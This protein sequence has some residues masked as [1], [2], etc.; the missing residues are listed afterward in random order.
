MESTSAPGTS[1]VPPSLHPHPPN[2][3]LQQLLSRGRF[4]LYSWNLVGL[5][6]ALANRQC[7]VSGRDLEGTCSLGLSSLAALGALP[8]PEDVG[9]PCWRVKDLGLAAPATPAHSLPTA[10]C[11]TRP[12]WMVKPPDDP[13]DRHMRQPR[14]NWTNWPKPELSSWLI[15]SGATSGFW[16]YVT[17]LFRWACHL[18]PQPTG[19][20]TFT[21]HVLCTW[22]AGWWEV[23]PLQVAHWTHHDTAGSRQDWSLPAQPWHATEQEHTW[24]QSPASLTFPEPKVLLG[25]EDSSSTCW[26]KAR[27]GNLNR[28]W[29][30][31]EWGSSQPRTLPGRRGDS[32]RLDHTKPQ[33]PRACSMDPWNFT[34][35]MQMER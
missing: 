13:Y 21:L 23:C 32:R 16:L 22:M 25:A 28:A 31:G 14:R 20:T 18:N 10:T 2:V 24:A 1:F 34:F 17:L 35:K 7:H 30:T 8:L 12:A 9:V 26:V 29:S 15:G 11:H 4:F 19:R 5:C 33:T 27:K 6:L 3:I